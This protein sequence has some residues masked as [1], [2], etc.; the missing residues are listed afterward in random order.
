MQAF[1]VVHGFVIGPRVTLTGDVQ[2]DHIPIGL[3]S[4]IQPDDTRKREIYVSAGDNEFDNCTLEW[5]FDDPR[6]VP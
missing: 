1:I 6:S 3:H 5:A 2:W 4:T